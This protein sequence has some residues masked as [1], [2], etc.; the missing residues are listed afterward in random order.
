MR[1]TQQHHGRDTPCP[2]PTLQT[3]SAH[4]ESSP[5]H[6][7]SVDGQDHGGLQI[8]SN[9][10]ES[11]SETVVGD[12]AETGSGCPSKC[13]RAVMDQL[14]PA[15]LVATGPIKDCLG[16]FSSVLNHA[17]A[18]STQHKEHQT[19]QGLELQQEAIQLQK[20][21]L[22]VDREHNRLLGQIVE[23]LVVSPDSKENNPV[24]SS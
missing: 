1:Q 10:D 23:R 5:E 18:E 16:E 11:D 3:Q 15:L 22:K 13:Q 21:Q 14:D 2:S 20:E 7:T 12:D 6:E 24:E 8:G 17:K 4:S 9:H 19:A